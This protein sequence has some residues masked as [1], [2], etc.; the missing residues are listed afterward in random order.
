[1]MTE[2]TSRSGHSPVARLERPNENRWV[3]GVARG[4][5]VKY[6]IGVGWI[7]LAFTLLTFAGGLGIVLYAAGWLT[8]PDEGERQSILDRTIGE[9]DQPGRWVGIGL[10][11]TAALI[12]VG[13]TGLVRGELLFAGVLVLAGLLLYRGEAP[14]RRPPTHGPPSPGTGPDEEGVDSNAEQG[15][16]PDEPDAVGRL[17]VEPLVGSDGSDGGPAGPTPPSG[18]AKP[19]RPPRA[20]SPLGLYTVAIVLIVF[21]IMS[22]VAANTDLDRDLRDLIGAGFIVLG[23]GL[24][25]GTWFGR[26]RSLIAL[27]LVLLPVAAA[28]FIVEVPLR[29]N[30]G[31]LTYRVPSAETSPVYEQL[32]GEMRLDLRDFDLE[33]QGVVHA[34]LGFGKLLVLLPE[35]LDPVLVTQVGVGALELDW[36][37]RNGFDFD[38]TIDLGGDGDVVLDLRVGIGQI[39][40]EEE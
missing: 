25:V 2:S 27:G 17:A 6:D 18:S 32:A 21:G 24:L 38:R 28:A 1:M 20:R 11:A 19:A 34:S 37:S 15:S 22:A 7:R 26:A 16:A 14:L 9:I 23:A 35:G 4:L 29:G 12:V 36:F 13:W 5:S 39:D 3:A 40:V 10:I 33:S 8:L 30:V 31:D